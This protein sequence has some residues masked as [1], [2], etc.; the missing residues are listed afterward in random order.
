G[1]G[2]EQFASRPFG[3]LAR[4]FR[5]PLVRN[6]GEPRSKCLWCRAPNHGCRPASVLNSAILLLATGLPAGLLSLPLVAMTEREQPD[7][8]PPQRVGPRLRQPVDGPFERDL[9]RAASLLHLDGA[10]SFR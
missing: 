6:G 4:S 8:P 5:D 2:R 9:S 7:V 1:D 10:V 3:A